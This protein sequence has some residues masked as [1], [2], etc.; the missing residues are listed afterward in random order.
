MDSLTPEPCE[1]IRLARKCGLYSILPAAF[2]HLSRI[3]GTADRHFSQVMQDDRE[4]SRVVVEGE[5]TAE[6]SL[7]SVED[8]RCLIIGRDAIFEVFKEYLDEATEKAMHGHCAASDPSECIRNLYKFG[9]QLEVEMLRNRDPLFL[10]KDGGTCFIWPLQTCEPCRGMFLATLEASRE[11]F[12]RKLPAL[13]LLK[14][15]S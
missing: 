15:M 13:F 12:W 6:F 11:A 3:R 1:A 14:S 5:R 9:D 2:Y 7:L 8:F 10:M 4:T